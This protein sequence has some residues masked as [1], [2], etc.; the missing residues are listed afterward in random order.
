MTNPQKSITIFSLPKIIRLIID[1][2]FKRDSF[3]NI[4]S[5]DIFDTRHFLQEKLHTVHLVYIFLLL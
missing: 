3:K 2:D 4:E 5:M 1:L